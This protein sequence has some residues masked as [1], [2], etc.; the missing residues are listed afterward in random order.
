LSYDRNNFLEAGK[1][2]VDS[3]TNHRTTLENLV[4]WAGQIIGSN[5]ASLYLLDTSSGNLH[6]SILWNIPDSY[7][8]GCKEVPLGTQCCGRAALHKTPWIVT[9][10]LE[11][12][13]FAD[14]REAALASGMRSGFSVPVMHDDQV[15]GTVGYQFVNPHVPGSDEIARATDMAELVAYALHRFGIKSFA[16]PK[17]NAASVGQPFQG[18]DATTGTE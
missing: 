8:G 5:S 16:A 17:R 3:S 4:R 15:L 7:L 11:D 9:D 6:P 14:C 12:P 18:Q 10:M 2:H 13:T 1:R